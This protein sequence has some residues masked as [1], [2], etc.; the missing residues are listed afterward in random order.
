M[1]IIVIF[2]SMTHHNISYILLY[3][4]IIYYT[5]CYC[6]HTTC[7]NLSE[8]PF[9]Y[10]K[11]KY[12]CS[13]NHKSDCR[14]STSY[15]TLRV[16]KIFRVQFIGTLP[17]ECSHKHQK[18]SSNHCYHSVHSISIS[19]IRLSTSARKNIIPPI[20]AAHILFSLSCSLPKIA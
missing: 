7:S 9:R 10:W 13:E 12:K 14:N 8:Q 4:Y 1:L 18:N 2:I 5:K 16:N 11:K 17:L 15:Y 3:I 6:P 19:L 20:T